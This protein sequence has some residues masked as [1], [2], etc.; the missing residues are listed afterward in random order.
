MPARQPATTR[1]RSKAARTGR[2]GINEFAAQNGSHRP[3][4]HQRVRRFSAVGASAPACASTR[5]RSSP[6]SRRAISRSRC[7]R[8]SV[9]LRRHSNLRANRGVGFIDADEL[10]PVWAAPSEERDAS[11]G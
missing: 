3:N 2:T 6:V 5:S 10:A 4:G 1:G 8:S 7:A 9:G 11:T